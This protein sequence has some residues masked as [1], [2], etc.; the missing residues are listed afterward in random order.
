MTNVGPANIYPLAKRHYRLLRLPLPL[1]LLLPLPLRLLPLPERLDPE[2]ELR[3]PELDLLELDPERPPPLPLEREWLLARSRD[4]R[5][6]SARARNH[7]FWLL[8]A[9]RAYTNAP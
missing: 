5:R 9:L 7:R 1:P 4:R 6:S 3:D 2:L 8:S